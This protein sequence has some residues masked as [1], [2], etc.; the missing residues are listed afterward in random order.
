MHAELIARENEF[1]RADT[2]LL[3]SADQKLNPNC[4]VIALGV[5]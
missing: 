5:K 3:G 1:Y 4:P 2:R